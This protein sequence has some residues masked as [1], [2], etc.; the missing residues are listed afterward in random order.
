MAVSAQTFRAKHTDARAGCAPRPHSQPIQ[1]RAAQLQSPFLLPDEPNGHRYE[2]KV[3]FITGAARGPDRGSPVC[4]RGRG[5][6]RPLYLRRSAHQPWTRARPRGPRRNVR[7]HRSRDSFA[8]RQGRVVAWIAS[9]EA[10]HVTGSSYG[11]TSIAPTAEPMVHGAQSG[12]QL[13]C[14]SRP[15]DQ[16]RMSRTWRQHRAG[17][18]HVFLRM[19]HGLPRRRPR[20]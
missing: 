20:W 4:R 17:H 2:G 8:R 16:S 18:H 10:R 14:V 11:S 5:H 6:H 9:N 7:G 1:R 12:C 15:S 3:V 19:S 13:G